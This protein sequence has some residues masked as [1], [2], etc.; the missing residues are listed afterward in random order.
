M[1]IRIILL[2]FF[3]ASH[4]IFSQ[5][6]EFQV[7][8]HADGSPIVSEKFELLEKTIPYLTGQNNNTPTINLPKE[9]Q[10]QIRTDEDTQV[11]DSDEI[12]FEIHAAINPYDPSNIIVG[13][14]HYDPSGF[15]LPILDFA[16]YYTNDFGTTWSKSPFNG[17]FPG[18]NVIGGG[19]P[20]IT[21]DENGTAYYSW[22]ALT[23]TAGTQN[24]TWGL[25][26]A[27]ST[28]GG[29]NWIVDATGIEKNPFQNLNVNTLTHAPDKQWMASDHS[30]SSD[31]IGNVYIVYTD[32]NIANPA[33]R[34]TL[35]RRVPGSTNFEDTGV[36]FNSQNY[37]IA[38]FSSIDV[39]TDGT[40]YVSFFAD[41]GGNNYAM[42]MTKSTDGGVTFT[43]ETKVADLDLP[44]LFSGDPAV[45]GISEN[46]LYPCPHL[47]IDP[48]ATETIYM[49]WSDVATNTAA[50]GLNIYLTKSTDGGNSW[51]TPLKVNNNTDVESNQFYSSI[52]V[53]E[54]GVVFLS[55]Y[56]QRDNTGN[57]ETH[58]YFA[59]SLDGGNTFEQM[60]IT[61]VASDFGQIGMLNDLG[62]GEY[63]EIVTTGD[64]AIPFWSDGR[65]NNGQI[66]V[67]SAFLNI[68]ELNVNEIKSLNTKFSFIGPKPNPIQEQA[69]FDLLLNEKS[70]VE[71]LLFD[72]VGRQLRTI[73]KQ[74]FT[75]GSHTIEFKTTN[76]AN[77]E[78][79]VTINT[80][81]GSQTKKIIIAK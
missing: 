45:P 46:R 51:S 67:Y 19:D 1:K 54:S 26:Y 47:A 27:T 41:Q 38:Q 13:A 14:M 31:H 37:A 44:A 32:I 28:N 57:N 5:T 75:A 80:D 3:F 72:V 70:D 78:Y 50:S 7:P 35:K 21:F 10:A 63:N 34:M 65:T 43:P 55:W 6:Q 56:D 71:I 12:E 64:Y 16:V 60:N 18:E 61:S 39:A 58:Y 74:D 9:L 40:V 20:M 11:G 77:G 79:F 68:Q 15:P 62:P 48:S 76:L 30:P 36:I 8:T 17:T 81:F 73:T 33:Y 52:A 69:I 22:V 42:F 24:G 2:L 29:A 53:N 25:Y 23:V 59:F 49:T 66:A 4:S